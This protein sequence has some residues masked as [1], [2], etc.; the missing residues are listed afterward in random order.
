MDTHTLIQAFDTEEGKRIFSRFLSC[1]EDFHMRPALAR[2][3]LLGFSGGADSVLCA[4][5][6]LRL[7][8]IIFDFPLV[9]CHINHGIRGES[10]HRDQA[11]CERFAN[12]LSL[13][14]Y[15]R[16]IDVPTSAKQM[17]IGIEECA[18]KMRYEQF[19]HIIRGRNDIQT[20]VTAHNATDNLETVLQRLFRGTGMKGMCG[21]PV[22]RKNVLRP[23]LYIPKKEIVDFLSKNQ[24]PFVTDETNFDSGYTRN[25]IRNEIFP[26]LERLTDE[27]EES[28]LRFVQNLRE[29][30]ECLSSLAD[31]FLLRFPSGT[32]DTEHFLKLPKAVRS[33]V[34]V[35]LVKKVAPDAML[36]RM[37][38][39]GALSAIEEGKRRYSLVCDLILNCEKGYIYIDSQKSLFPFDASLPLN[40][41]VWIDSLDACF[42]LCDRESFK[43]F[44]NVY[45]IAIQEAI[46][47]GI[48]NGELSVRTKRDG[49]AYAY[50][51]ITRKLKKLFNDRSIPPRFRDLI[52]VICDVS[53]I[54]WVPGFRVRECKNV[55]SDKKIYIAVALPK[56][57][58]DFDKSYRF[59]IGNEFC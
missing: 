51:G 16:T 25:Y 34:L 41:E 36:E 30:E 37:H 29:D 13:P 49:D 32:V 10:A 15:A 21:I 33:R 23:M 5:L 35:S 48:I 3:V 57:M 58:D 17:R 9:L 50:G 44:S 19:D 24:I 53:G 20:I 38:I 1:I 7:K 55:K 56:E 27:P 31:E 42:V 52:P 11:F 47:F 54:I 22:A 12:E 4:A 28:I 43:S 45:K 26:L 8:H 40:Q 6:L 14:Y 39:Q 18:R 2:G 59:Y 46:D